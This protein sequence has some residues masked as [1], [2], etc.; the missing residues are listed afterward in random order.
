MPVIGMNIKGMEAS[1]ISEEAS[2]KIDISSTPKI[3]D[4]KEVDFNL[5]GKKVLSVS[6][7]FTTSY[8]PKIGKIRLSGELFY[9]SKDPK[10]L[11]KQW[12]KEKKLP[13]PVSMEILNHLFRRCLIKTAQISEDLQLPPPIQMPR[14]VPKKAEAS[15]VG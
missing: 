15:Y 3:T 6:Y 13:E 7:E 10:E 9:M 14:V 5:V 11:S 4:I 2:Q 12:K 1:K 8:E